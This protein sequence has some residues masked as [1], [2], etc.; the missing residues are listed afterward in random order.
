ME[1]NVRVD[2]ACEAVGVHGSHSSSSMGVEL[3][4]LACTKLGRSVMHH[5]ACWRWDLAASGAV[6]RLG[7][8]RKGGAEHG[9]AAWSW[10]RLGLCSMVTCYCAWNSCGLQHEGGAGN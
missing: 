3:A 2:C 9:E 8:C 5:L 10:R 4:K 6:A 7:V 1:G